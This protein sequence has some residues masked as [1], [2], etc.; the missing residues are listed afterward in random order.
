[1]EIA[2]LIIDTDPREETSIRSL[3]EKMP[4]PL[5]FIDTADPRPG[6]NG[7]D[8]VIFGLPHNPKHE[9]RLKKTLA[10]VRTTSPHAQVILL[11]P[12][13]LTNLDEKI[14]EYEARSILLKPIDEITFTSFFEKI[15]S[16]LLR[17]KEREDYNKETSK[18]SRITDIIGRS[19]AINDVLSLLEKVS[20]SRS[21]SVLL[22]GETGTG[23]SLFARYIH[24][25][26]DRS[27]GPFIEINCA[28]LPANLMESELFGYEP[29]AFT[30]AKTQK[31][32]LIELGDR[33]TLFFDEVT[34]IEFLTQAKLLKFLDSKKLRRLGGDREIPVD[35]RVIAASNRNL[36]EEVRLKNFREDLFYRLNVVEIRIPPLR[37]RKLDVVMIAEHYL[38]EFKTKFNKR[39]LRFSSRAIEMIRDYP[40]PGNVRELINVLERAVLLCKDE[41]IQRDDLPIEKNAIKNEIIFSKDLDDF[42]VKLPPGGISLEAIEKKVIEEMLRRTRGNVLKAARLL[43]ISR[44]SLR[45]KMLKYK[46]DSRPFHKKILVEV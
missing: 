46:I 26:S 42:A 20:Q 12:R 1:M 4:F 28:A 16:P 9:P 6:K 38:D 15:L 11:A 40:W 31:I 45:Y 23:K 34:E 32:G 39:Y 18:A 13:I 24:E 8:V 41:S 35:T 33:G 10:N 5:R 27:K 36:K 19:D 3:L 30:D 25:L 21:T 22:L 44:G 43:T 17:R 29:G 37:D 14:L 7:V 2:I